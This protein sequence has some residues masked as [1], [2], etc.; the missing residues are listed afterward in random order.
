MSKARIEGAEY[1]TL[2]RRC[3][4]EIAQKFW[5]LGQALADQDQRRGVAAG[6]EEIED[7]QVEM[8]RGMG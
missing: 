6:D 1:Q 5:L 2:I 3:R 4:Q 8:K 7:R